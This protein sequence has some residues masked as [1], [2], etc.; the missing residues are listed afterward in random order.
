MPRELLFSV[1]TK[2]GLTVETFRSG[3]AGGQNQ[4]KR[5]TGVRVRHDASKSVGE[6][7]EERSQL[8]NKRTALK[9]MAATPTFLFWVH[10]ESKRLQGHQSAEE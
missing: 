4:N 5:D 1:T 6:S 7:R 9:R 10:E 8:Q 2:N 3:G